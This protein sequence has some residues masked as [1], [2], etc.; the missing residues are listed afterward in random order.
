MTLNGDGSGE[1]K[2]L[3]VFASA[4]T[5]AKVDVVGLVGEL[6]LAG[7]GARTFA[8]AASASSGDLE[9]AVAL[10][11][12]QG[13]ERYGRATV[14]WACR[15]VRKNAARIRF[16]A[17]TLEKERRLS[18][19]Q[20]ALI[21]GGPAHATHAPRPSEFKPRPRVP[22]ATVHAPGPDL[23]PKPKA[24]ATRAPVKVLRIA[25]PVRPSKAALDKLET[26]WRRMARAGMLS[27]P[28]AR[29]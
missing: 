26:K 15:F 21:L 22:G 20:V 17:W 24:E 16:L 23:S 9:R 27:D 29:R 4:D 13:G 2:C 1:T 12:A 25:F 3:S 8:K 28:R 6:L 10:V 11:N 18:G 14:A 5:R 19:E 7:D